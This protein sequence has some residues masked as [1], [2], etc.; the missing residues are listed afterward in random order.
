MFCGLFPCTKSLKR[1]QLSVYIIGNRSLLSKPTMARFLILVQ[2][3]GK[4]SYQ[5]VNQ[6]E[7]VLKGKGM[8][9][10]WTERPERERA[11]EGLFGAFFCDV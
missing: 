7:V 3:T 10:F 11:L 8:H 4:D 6:R 5:E 9:K 2:R 1:A